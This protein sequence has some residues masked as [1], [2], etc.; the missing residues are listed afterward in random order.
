MAAAPDRGTA[1]VW[2]PEEDLARVVALL[3]KH[4]G[5]RVE[6]GRLA[7]AVEIGPQAFERVPPAAQAEQR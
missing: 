6:F 5:F 3:L 1:L 4:A 7:R 2:V